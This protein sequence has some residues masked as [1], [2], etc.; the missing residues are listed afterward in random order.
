M[1]GFFP[2]T[3]I[4]RQVPRPNLSQKNPSSQPN[5]RPRKSTKTKLAGRLSSVSQPD[6]V[7]LSTNLF[8]KINVSL[9]LVPGELNFEE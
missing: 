4:F 9:P 2:I 5:F 1:S 8:F 6:Q 7:V 3:P